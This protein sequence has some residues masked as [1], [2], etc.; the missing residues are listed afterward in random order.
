[1]GYT[2]R[3]PFVDKYT[4]L[5]IVKVSMGTTAKQK[6]RNRSFNVQCILYSLT[7]LNTLS[8]AIDDI[9]PYISLVGVIHHD[10]KSNL[11]REGDN[12]SKT[13]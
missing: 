12:F 7:V 6:V 3:A 1:M 13:Y 4:G 10:K 8:S 9:I 5:T 2:R 11:V